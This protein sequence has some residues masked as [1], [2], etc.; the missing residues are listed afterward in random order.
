ME[1]AKT[2]G[3]GTWLLGDSSTWVSCLVPGMFCGDGDGGTG[4]AQ[5]LGR[6][7]GEADRGSARSGGKEK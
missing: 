7:L 5:G 6:V 2:P 1:R 4:K 3:S